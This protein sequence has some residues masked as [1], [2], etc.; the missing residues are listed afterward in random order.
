MTGLP[1]LASWKSR[2]SLDLLEL[3]ALEQSTRCA[4]PRSRSVKSLWRRQNSSV[5]KVSMKVTS[6]VELADL[7]DLLAPEAVCWSHFAFA[8]MSSHASYSA[9]NW[10]R[11][12][13]LSMSR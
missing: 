4:S 9:P 8:S 1:K 5:R 13:R 6:L 11:F 10:P 2:A 7:E 12:Q 3:A